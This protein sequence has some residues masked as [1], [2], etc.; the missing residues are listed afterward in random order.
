MHLFGSIARQT[1]WALYFPDAQCW[2]SF[3]YFDFHCRAKKQNPL[4]T[5]LSHSVIRQVP[6]KTGFFATLSSSFKT[7]QGQ[8][9]GGFTV[10]KS[11]TYGIHDLPRSGRPCQAKHDSPLHGARL[12][13]QPVMKQREGW[14]I[15]LSAENDSWEHDWLCFL[16]YAFW[17]GNH[18]RVAPDK[19]KCSVNILVWLLKLKVIDMGLWKM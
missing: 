1:Y 17:K 6:P 3:V 8:V 16:H 4:R 2:P 10:C 13:H 15:I 11:F 5:W 9:L 12:L 14:K 18:L 7:L 19:R